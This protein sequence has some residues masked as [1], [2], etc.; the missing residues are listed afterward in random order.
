MRPSHAV[1]GQIKLPLRIP[2]SP[3]REGSGMLLRGY[4]H[5]IL[6]R[7]RA[8]RTA[9]DC[10]RPPARKERRVMNLGSSMV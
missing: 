2:E 6:C 8:R 1:G 10:A 5:F 7:P 3:T 4:V 9:L